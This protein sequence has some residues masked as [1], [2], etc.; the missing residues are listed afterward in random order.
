[1]PSLAQIHQGVEFIRCLAAE[2]HMDKDEL[3][4]HIQNVNRKLHIKH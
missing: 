3:I 1:M 2:L 4:F